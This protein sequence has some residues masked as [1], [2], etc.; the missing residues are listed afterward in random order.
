M[1]PQSVG[2]NAVNVREWANVES[3]SWW[4]SLLNAI[5][6]MNVKEDPDGKQESMFEHKK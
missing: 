6:R 2:G 4:D 5:L 3:I 1:Q